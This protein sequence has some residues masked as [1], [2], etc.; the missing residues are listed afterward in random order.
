MVAGL[1]VV[2]AESASFDLQI[3]DSTVSDFGLT[4]IFIDHNGSA[5]T[6]RIS[7]S[8][9]SRNSQ[10]EGQGGFHIQ[11]RGALDLQLEEDRV[12]DNKGGGISIFGQSQLTVVMRNNLVSDNDDPSIDQKKQCQFQQ[13]CCIQLQQGLVE[14]CPH[15]CPPPPCCG[16]TQGCA[17]LVDDQ[18]SSTVTIVNT[19]I[20]RHEC[21]AS[22]VYVASSGNTEM[23]LTN[24]ILYGNGGIDLYNDQ[25]S[26]R[27]T[28]SHSD[29]GVVSGSYTNAGGNISADPRFIAPDTSD[30][31]LGRF[32]PLS[33]KLV[34]Y[35]P[36]NPDLCG[37]GA[38]ATNHA[39]TGRKA[40]E[41]PF[42][43]LF[44]AVTSSSIVT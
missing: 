28:M 4:G 9:I 31:H 18:G 37:S 43:A 35:L 30:Y 14:S 23:R 27:L 8:Y 3:D 32:S 29:V 39:G 33:R 26:A 10:L 15:P 21:A 19:T 22:G 1:S 6:A 2:S 5:S 12:F 42:R 16:C 34:D 20:T 17:L 13:L 11:G 24:S 7:R 41:H 38:R 44:T 36:C 25:N 40:P